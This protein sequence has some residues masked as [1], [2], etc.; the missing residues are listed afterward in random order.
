VAAACL[1]QEYRDTTRYT[2]YRQ[3]LDFHDF[4]RLFVDGWEFLDSPEHKKTVALAVDAKPWEHCWLF[5]P[6]L[7]RSLQNDAVYVSTQHKWDVPAWLEGESHKRSDE[8]LWLNNLTKQSVDYV[9]VFSKPIELVW[10]R[11]YKD[12]F[13]IVFDAKEYKIFAYQPLESS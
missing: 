7:G 2:Y 4:P 13:Q 5:Y 1:L 9:F 8:A 3:H 11:K 12:L 10:I 6:L